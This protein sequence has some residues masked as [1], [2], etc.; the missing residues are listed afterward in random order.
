[1][2]MSRDNDITSQYYLAVTIHND[3]VMQSCLP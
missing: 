2:N 3:N 1:M